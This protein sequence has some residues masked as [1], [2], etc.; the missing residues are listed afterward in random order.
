MQ[1]AFRSARS[2]QRKLKAA[3][4]RLKT[5]N[6]ALKKKVEELEAQQRKSAASDEDSKKRKREESMEIPFDEE[7]QKRPKTSNGNMASEHVPRCLRD[8]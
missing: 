2:E 5:E 7:L 1:V 6:A 4:T 3:N 8:R